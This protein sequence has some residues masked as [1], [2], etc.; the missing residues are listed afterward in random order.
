[1]SSIKQNI[2]LLS[3]LKNGFL[4]F[5]DL[6]KLANASYAKICELAIEKKNLTLLSSCLEK[7]VENK[8]EQDIINHLVIM[9]QFENTTLFQFCVNLEWID[10]CQKIVTHLGPSLGYSTQGRS[11][12]SACLYSFIDLEDERFLWLLDKLEYD[13]TNDQS[14]MQPIHYITRQKDP[15]FVFNLLRKKGV[16]LQHPSFNG[17]LL[18][19]F[20]NFYNNRYKINPNSPKVDGVRRVISDLVVEVPLSE[21]QAIRRLYHKKFHK[22]E[23][24]KSIGQELRIREERDVVLEV[25]SNSEAA[26]Q[27]QVGEG[28]QRVA[29]RESKVRR[30]NKI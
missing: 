1:M 15:F 29:N 7:V 22:V 10:G 12:L 30:V 6:A 4:S 11:A 25:M 21:V 23:H 18:V 27:R 9:N 2:F 5:I 13:Y 26:A 20:I 28:L 14:S 17:E 24:L 3:L 8:K 16:D 19:Y